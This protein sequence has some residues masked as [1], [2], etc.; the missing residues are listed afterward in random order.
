[1]TYP[2]LHISLA[3][4]NNIVEN[5][6]NYR[7]L[8]SYDGTL[9]SGWQIQPNATSIQELVQQAVRTITRRDVTVIGSGRTDAGVHAIGQVAHFK[10]DLALELYRF[11]GSLNGI[12]PPDIRILQ[13]EEAPLDFHAQRSATRKTYRYHICLNHVQSPFQRLYSLHMRDP[14]DLQLLAEAIACFKGT[15]DFTAFANEAHKGAAAGNPVRTLYRAEAIPEEC[16]VRLEFEG[17]GFLYK[18]VRNMVGTILDVARGKRP[19]DDIAQLFA[20]RD[21]RATAAAA[22]PHGLFLVKVEYPHAN[23]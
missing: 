12:L 16:G 15:H 20:H 6:F 14:L 11:W 10:C 23:S 1:M 3:S 8:I 18:M 7:L 22:P 2:W 5:L 13:V 4:W 21:R 17:D 9:Y 19:L